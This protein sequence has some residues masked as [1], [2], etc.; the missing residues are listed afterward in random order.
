MV[1]IV[2]EIPRGKSETVEFSTW[3]QQQSR[4]RFGVAHTRIA[5][6]PFPH[7]LDVAGVTGKAVGVATE[8]CAEI[9]G[10]DDGVLSPR[11]L[12]GEG[13]RGEVT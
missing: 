4:G 7:D 3:R 11:R 1:H 10:D 13:R 8:S 12:Q 9:Y 5:S 2:I 6:L